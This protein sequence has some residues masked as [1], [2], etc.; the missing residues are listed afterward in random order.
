MLP[1]DL[2]RVKSAHAR[3]L[4]LPPGERDDF[5]RGQFPDE[6]ELQQALKKLLEWHDQAGEFLSTPLASRILEPLARDFKPQRVG[7]WELVRELGRGGSATVYLARRADDLF[8]KQVAIKLLNRLS[9][10]E[11]VFR[12]FQREIQILARVEHP[13]IVRLLEAGTTGEA[14]AYIVTEFV[15]GKPIDEFAASLPLREKLELFLKVCLGVS[16]AHQNSIV[17][18]D[19][20]P[21]NI[22]VAGDGTPKL[23]DF[24][25]T[26]LLDQDSRL[27]ETGLERMT[28]RYASPEQIRREKDITIASDVYSLGVVLYE[29]VARRSP[30]GGAEHELAARILSDDPLACPEAPR[31]LEAVARKALR[32]APDERY[33]SV[34]SFQEDVARV[35]EG[36]PVKARSQRRW[37]ISLFAS[38]AALVLLAG[39]AFRA[40]RPPQDRTS[41]I[42]LEASEGRPLSFNF[43]PDAR[44]LYYA[45]GDTFFDYADIFVKDLQTG[46]VTQLTRDRV[47]KIGPVVS[48][49][50]KFIAFQ[51]AVTRTLFVLP[52]SGGEERKLFTAPVEDFA[53]GAD[54]ESLIV[55]H[56]SDDGIW[57]HLRGFNIRTSEWWQITDPPKE[58]RGDHFAA[59]SPDGKTLCF[60]R[61]E[62]RESADLFLLPVDA[63]LRP[64]GTPRRLTS[65]RFRIGFPYWTPDGRKIIYTS[66]TLGNFGLFR[67]AVDGRSE[68]IEVTE[69]GSGIEALA[70]PRRG[71]QLV[72]GRWK[73]EDSIWRLD[74]ESS[75][76]RVVGP[77]K[78]AVST[79]QEDGGAFSP[80]GRFISFVSGRSGEPQVWVAHADGTAV[81]QV[82]FHPGP[83]IISPLWL[84]DNSGMLV[85][86]RSRAVGLRNLIMKPAGGPERE[87]AGLTG[88][89]GAFS[90]DGKWLYFSLIKKD[91]DIYKYSMETGEIRQ[92]THDARGSYGVESPD[93]QTVYFSKPESELGLWRVPARGGPPSQVLVNLARRTLFAVR[94]EGI[95]YMEREPRSVVMKLRQFSDGRDRELYRTKAIPNWGFS[96]SPDARSI[97][98]GQQDV[99]TSE[100]V[101][102]KNFD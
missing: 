87:L 55:S 100:V 17:H 52:S 86:V 85:S 7:P 22:L 68:P 93:G 10:S 13:Y 18:R 37:R 14:L 66:G 77:T 34:K 99:V 72:V 39:I 45:A 6:P 29:L 32:K 54:S 38:A 19:I 70:V 49:D 75:S 98:F 15:D 50:G 63:K 47:F 78:L 11:E 5:L 43:S 92:V 65:R 69:A 48:P 24:G 88:I 36:E 74:F 89:P 33:E 26:L 40:S 79:G 96:F 82:T 23:L 35:L 71:H 1:E 80:D 27:T 42:S 61:Q 4:T 56:R 53:W 8:E 2:E 91:I 97:Q 21:S 3:A 58:G 30:Y 94:N 83:D 90:H 76:A 46:K 12:R 41:L 44:R 60:V 84:P 95:Y 28:I 81:R 64:L 25:I 59:L 51:R 20:K 101:L 31:D 62:A 9:H 57:P 67:V 102:I 73:T 16:A